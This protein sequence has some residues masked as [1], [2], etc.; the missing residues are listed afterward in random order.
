MWSWLQRRELTRAHQIARLQ[1][2]Q[3][4]LKEHRDGITDHVLKE[5]TEKE[6]KHLRTRCT[7]GLQDDRRCQLFACPSSMD[8]IFVHARRADLISAVARCGP[9]TLLVPLSADGIPG[10]DSQVMGVRLDLGFV[11]LPECQVRIWGLAAANAQ[12]LFA[13]FEDDEE[14]GG[15]QP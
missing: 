9:W 3:T 7:Q 14:E 15:S 13:P 5:R 1:R 11:P 10:D 4:L 12:C 8:L 6:I 2:L